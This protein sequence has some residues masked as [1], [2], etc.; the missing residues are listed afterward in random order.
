MAKRT[1]V[2][3]V[4]YFPVFPGIQYKNLIFSITFKDIAQ[5]TTAE[6]CSLHLVKMAK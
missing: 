5:S 3:P 1:K 6:K 2:I 4:N